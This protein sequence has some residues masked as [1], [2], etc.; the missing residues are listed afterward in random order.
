MFYKKKENNLH[1]FKSDKDNFWFW[2]FE[3]ILEDSEI[4]NKI[5]NFK[6]YKHIWWR[7]LGI[8][9]IFEY[10]NWLKLKYMDKIETNEEDK[11]LF[12]IVNSINNIDFIDENNF[13]NILDLS[14]DFYIKDS[15]HWWILNI[16]KSTFL[17][18]FPVLNWYV[19]KYWFYDKVN[20]WLDSSLLN[21]QNIYEIEFDEEKINRIP[22]HSQEIKDFLNSWKLLTN[23]KKKEFHNLLY[24]DIYLLLVN[25][26]K[27]YFIIYKAIKNKE[28][29]KTIIESENILQEYK[30]Q[31]ILLEYTSNIN[32]EKMFNQIDLLVKQI[33]ILSEFYSLF[34][35]RYKLDF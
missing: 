34:I 1:Y 35:K 16:D 20:L 6:T 17:N 7:W 15:I 27:L 8:D 32:I 24:N 9:F 23:S 2:P 19:N 28:E 3:N 13:K 26:I 33:D 11:I 22:N 25:I 10:S 21:L 5:D 30:S 29:L 18:L 12:F 4:K 31:A 14:E